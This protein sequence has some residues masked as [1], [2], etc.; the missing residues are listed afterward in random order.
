MKGQ[1]F[2][3][4]VLVAMLMMV[5]IAMYFSSTNQISAYKTYSYKPFLANKLVETKLEMVSAFIES[6][7][8]ENNFDF[9]NHV[10]NLM[11][12]SASERAESIKT[13][14]TITQNG[15]QFT[16]D[17][18]NLELV[19]G[20]DY[21]KTYFTY[22]YTVPF[23][24]KTFKDKNRAYQTDVF[25]TGDTVYY[26]ITGNNS[27][28]INVTVYSPSGQ[29]FQNTTA[30]LV[31]WHWNSS[32][33]PNAPGDWKI[34]VIDTNSSQT[35]TKMIHY[36]TKDIQIKTYKGQT[37]TRSFNWG[38]SLNITVHLTDYKGNNI[39]CPIN[40][41]VKSTNGKLFGH[42]QGIPSNGI[43]SKEFY[44]SNNL[45]AGVMNITVT[46]ECTWFQNSTYITLGL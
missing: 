39:N 37:E 11:N 6:I 27:D 19:S 38:D 18:S 36:M 7:Y 33:T 20:P 46:E 30:K 10:L 15:S 26:W 41:I 44:L 29:I 24:I 31:N 40:I 12:T 23:Q 45:M 28:N 22:K 5:A 1:Y 9:M 42:Y 35:I 2:L 25:E 34:E 8:Y 4:M 14:Y 17:V 21:A 13:T 3:P 43:L 16:L 32:F